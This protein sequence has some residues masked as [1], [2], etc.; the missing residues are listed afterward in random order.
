MAKR[1][2]TAEQ[3]YKRNQK[4]AKFFKVLAPV[5][6]WGFLCLA[7]FCLIFA[8][9]HSF[10]NVRE[11]LE[12]LDDKKY[13]GESLLQNY[14]FLI[15]KYGEWVIGN[16][17]AGFQVKFVNVGN[18]VFSKLMIMNCLFFIVFLS[19]AFLLGKWLLPKIANQI[20]AAN[21]DMVNLMVLKG[22]E[23][24]KE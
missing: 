5:V 20:T 8:I 13:T 17:G 11:I 18:A 4:L 14:E 24:K 12:L 9:K 15:S 2:L 6:F 1:E 23:N 16:G 7:V 22:A 21:Q 3:K 19:S 10:G